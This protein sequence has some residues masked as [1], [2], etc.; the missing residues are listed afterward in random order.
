MSKQEVH[1]DIEG[2]RLAAEDDDKDNVTYS[3]NVSDVRVSSRP[4][5]IPKV[6]WHIYG[7]L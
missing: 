3:L 2:L 4:T 5:R 1:S 7:P 6:T